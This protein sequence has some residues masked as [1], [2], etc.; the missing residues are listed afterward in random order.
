M[1]YPIKPL[2]FDKGAAWGAAEP[3][4][5]KAQAAAAAGFVARMFAPFCELYAKMTKTRSVYTA[6]SVKTLTGGKQFSHEKAT[7]EL[8]YHTRDFKETVKDTVACLQRE[9]DG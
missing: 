4:G 3:Y 5:K 2:R 9:N 1:L 6:Y 7:K 8:S